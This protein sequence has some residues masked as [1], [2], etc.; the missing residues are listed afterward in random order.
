MSSGFVCDCSDIEY[1]GDNCQYFDGCHYEPCQNNG[2]CHRNGD[3]YFCECPL[4]YFGK[5]CEDFF[6]CEEKPREIVFVVDGSASV[7]FENFT[8][9]LDFIKTVVMNLGLSE[10]GTRASMV[11]YTFGDGDSVTEFGLID[12]VDDFVEQTDNIE[13]A[14]GF[15]LTGRAIYHAIND[16][17][18]TVRENAT[19]NFVVLTDGKS[20][21]NVLRPSNEARGLDVNMF[22]IG[23]KNY[24]LKQL[25]QIANR[26]WS[27]HLF[28]APDFD[29]LQQ[30]M[31]PLTRSLCSAE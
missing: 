19:V 11:Q 16:V 10:N 2:T 14:N 15:T 17:L 5:N 25:K 12:N 21:D 6:Q 28:L 26:P 23:V 20:Y 1:Y 9:Q 7:G 30:I 3:G 24:R 31:E 13:Y 29:I 8:A 4:Y 18:P 22:A 27:E